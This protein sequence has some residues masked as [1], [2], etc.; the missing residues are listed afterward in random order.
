MI[1]WNFTACHAFFFL[2]QKQQY[3]SIF[4]SPNISMLFTRKMLDILR[5]SYSLCLVSFCIRCV[6][7]VPVN[8]DI[9]YFLPIT[10]PCKGED[11]SE[12]LD[13]NVHDSIT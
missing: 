2:N 1:D 7:Y 4:V 9:L 5:Y 8:T 11:N 12:A 13:A 6:M 3:C 10:N